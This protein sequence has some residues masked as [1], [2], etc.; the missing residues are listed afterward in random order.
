MAPG[1]ILR[2]PLLRSIFPRGP[3]IPFTRPGTQNIATRTR[4]PPPRLRLPL[5][6]YASNSPPASP[7][8]SETPAAPQTL[9]A[10]LKALIKT[11]GWYAL[12][13]YTAVSI[14]DFS[15]TFAVIYLIGADQVTKVTSTAKEYIAEVLHK[16]PGGD[17][18]WDPAAETAQDSAIVKSGSE[19]L[20]AMIV[21][22]YGIHKTLLLP[23]RIGITAAVTPKFVGFLT[24]RGWVGQG[25]AR[26]AAQHVKDKVKKAKDGTQD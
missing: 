11:H 6:R 12:G 18:M 19:G 25:G 10:R 4:S 17:H 22:A 5:T 7:T 26:R 3:I 15:L 20:Y 9:T 24:R 8:S 13:V 2:I 21:L 23:F 1:R 14:L 16:D